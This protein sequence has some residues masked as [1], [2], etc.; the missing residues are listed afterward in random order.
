[1]IS[2]DLAE[3]LLSTDAASLSEPERDLKTLLLLDQSVH[4]DES[5]EDFFRGGGTA[6][7]V[8]AALDRVGATLAAPALKRLFLRLGAFDAQ[9]LAAA[10]DAN[11][12]GTLRRLRTGLDVYESVAADI[13]ASLERHAAS[14]GLI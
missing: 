4:G 8:V 14:H 12:E 11:D 6:A 10:L 13:D 1:V 7:D 5:F 9:A 2:P 3:R